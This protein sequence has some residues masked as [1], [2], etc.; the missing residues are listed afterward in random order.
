MSTQREEGIHKPRRQAPEE[1]KPGDTLT[2]D[3]Q[4]PGPRGS[5]CLLLAAR[6][7]VLPAA[8]AH[9]SSP[10]PCCLRGAP[11]IRE[12][13]QMSPPEYFLLLSS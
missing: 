3:C 2:S 4:P 13:S 9:G 7:V 11:Q 12:T 10:A 1:A 5:T 8:P 6:S